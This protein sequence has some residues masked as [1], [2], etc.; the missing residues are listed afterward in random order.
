MLRREVGCKVPWVARAGS[1][2]VLERTLV[3]PFLLPRGCCLKLEGVRKEQ[4]GWG[5]P[6][7]ALCADS[8]S[9]K[10]CR[11]APCSLLVPPPPGLLVLA[12]R[13]PRVPYVPAVDGLIDHWV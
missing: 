10:R 8:S 3:F 11:L 1:S 4:P 7:G 6:R 12:A 9:R 2:F 13:L 5:T